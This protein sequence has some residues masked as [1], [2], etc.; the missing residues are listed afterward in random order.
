MTPAP[1]VLVLALLTGAAHAQYK[2]VA[3][4]GAVTFQDAACPP[5]ARGERIDP[6]PAMNTTGPQTGANRPDY[7]RQA[8][9]ER[10]FAVGMTL[11]EVYLVAGAQSPIRENVTVT[12]RGTSR[13]MI[14][15]TAP[16][17]TI[18]VY[19]SEA[20]VVTAFQVVPH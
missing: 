18:Y 8:V 11:A 14:F 15:S 20:N 9:I 3:P 12:E 2:C 17:T 4:S 19:V 7:I 13:Q 10:R 5:A 1:F 16:A 6:K